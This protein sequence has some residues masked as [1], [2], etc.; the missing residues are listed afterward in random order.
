M[1]INR[2]WRLA[3]GTGT[4]AMAVGFGTVVAAGDGINL[5]DRSELIPLEQVGPDSGADDRAADSGS[6]ASPSDSVGLALEDS[7]RSA[8]SNA[9]YASAASPDLH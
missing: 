1:R 6:A 3:V 7:T 8:T 2:P 4:A 5:R 9:T